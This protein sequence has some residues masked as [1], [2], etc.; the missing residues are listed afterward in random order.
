[1]EL[2]FNMESI[3]HWSAFT[4]ICFP[5]KVGKDFLVSGYKIV[6]G[7]MVEFVTI[8]YFS[9]DRMWSDKNAVIRFWAELPEPIK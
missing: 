6:D 9:R 2:N 1:M 8:M 7:K 4:D 5:D 3:I